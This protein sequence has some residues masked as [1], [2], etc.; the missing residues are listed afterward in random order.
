MARR[1]GLARARRFHLLHERLDAT[2]AERIGLVDFMVEPGELAARAEEIVVRWSTGPTL[3]YGEIRRLM[4]SADHTPLETQ[5]EYETQGIVALARRE[6]AWNA[7][8]A[9]LDKREPVY[10]GR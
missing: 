9:F 10:S 2:T 1:I 6:D 8:R 7:L 5:L 4:Q 3:A